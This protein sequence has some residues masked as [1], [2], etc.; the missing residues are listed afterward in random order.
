MQFRNKNVWITGASSGIGEQLAYS[1]IRRGAR[2]IISSRDIT[3]LEKVKKNCMEIGGECHVF[4]IDLSD[5]QQSEKVADEIISRFESIDL[6]INNGGISQRSTAIET[7]SIVERKIMETNFFGAIAITKKV[8]PNMIKNGKG[9]IAITTSITGKFG[10]KLRSSYAASK[11]A[12]HGYFDSLRLELIGKNIDI[13]IVCPGFVKTEI[14]K[15]ALS[16][17]GLKHAKMDEGQQGGISPEKCGEKYIK[18]IEKNKKEVLI[19]GNEL[20]MVYLKR[21]LPFLFN[22]IASRVRAT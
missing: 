14:S 18:A 16:K 2:V 3:K 7:A 15:S 1:C 8:L 12:L 19:G 6:L 22:R 5:V 11:H 21:F 4:P 20:I 9:H 13:T 10:F 17:D